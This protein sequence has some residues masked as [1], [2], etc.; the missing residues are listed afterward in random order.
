MRKILIFSAFL[1]L[2]FFFFSSFSSKPAF[3][4]N[5]CGTGPCSPSCCGGSYS[6]PMC[7]GTTCQ[8]QGNYCSAGRCVYGWAGGQ[9]SSACNPACGS[10]GGVCT[11]G[12][13]KCTGSCSYQICNSSGQWG[14]DTTCVNSG[15]TTA[16]GIAS[17]QTSA[18]AQCNN[19]VTCASQGANAGCM[20]ATV[21]STT[22]GINVGT[23][24]C[25]TGNICCVPLGSG[26][27]GGPP[28]AQYPIGD[29]R[30]C[31]GANSECKPGGVNLSGR[32]CCPGFICK[33]YTSER[34]T[35]YRC[36]TA[37]KPPDAKRC[38]D[39]SCETAIGNIPT[40]PAGFV[41][42]LFSVLLSISGGIAIILIIIS[43]YKFMTSKGNPEQ[44]QVAREQLTAAVVGLLFVIFSL[45]ILQT[46]GVDI[47]KLPGFQR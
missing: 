39:S 44:V 40:D 8:T 5:T 9:P 15:C 24:N 18:A 3:A 46:I 32:T 36:G 35:E 45:V 6:A 47:L 11:P 1:F 43:G 7:N 38:L 42:K 41:Q 20:P 21:C 25:T 28:P 33:Q 29:G 10:T 23:L 13:R 26:G 31:Y 4:V 2:L 19:S 16:T 37:L 30:S 27:G 34:Q 14:S 12:A 22:A 17:C